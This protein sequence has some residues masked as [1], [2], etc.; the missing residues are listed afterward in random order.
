MVNIMLD[1]G[2]YIP[3]VL[4]VVEFLGMILIGVGRWIVS[5]APSWGSDQSTIHL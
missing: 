3:A 5:P 1:G 2:S 4:Q